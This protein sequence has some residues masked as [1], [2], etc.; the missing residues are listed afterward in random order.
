M[1]YCE[2]AGKRLP[3]EAE[4]EMACRAGKEDRLFPWGNKVRTLIHVTCNMWDEKIF[5]LFQWLPGG[6]HRANIWTGT[7]PS[8]NTEADGWRGT[9]P[10]T[11]FP[12]SKFGHKNMI[13]NVW[14]WTADWWTDQHVDKVKKGGSFMCHKVGNRFV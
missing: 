14:E 10:V 2:W 1:A 11:E 13:G 5:I 8:E 12:A 6:E 9:G 7:F 3:T 4:W